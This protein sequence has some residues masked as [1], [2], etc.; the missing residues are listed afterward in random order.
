VFWTFLIARQFTSGGTLDNSTLWL[1]V[2]VFPLVIGL[3]L[4]V[5]IAWRERSR[6]SAAHGQARAAS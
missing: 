4:L 5:F 2:G 6:R 3:A 1:A